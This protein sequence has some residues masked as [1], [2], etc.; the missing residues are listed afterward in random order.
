MARRILSA[1]ELLGRGL[2]LVAVALILLL[3]LGLS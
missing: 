2:L 1:A 3:A